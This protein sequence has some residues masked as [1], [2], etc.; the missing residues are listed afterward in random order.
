LKGKFVFL[1]FLTAKIEEG[2]KLIA[3]ETLEV[4]IKMF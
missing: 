3:I 2:D 4:Q 1:G